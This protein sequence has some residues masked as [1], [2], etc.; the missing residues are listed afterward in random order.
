LADVHPKSS[1]V[2]EYLALSEQHFNAYASAAETFKRAASNAAGIEKLRLLGRAANAHAADGASSLASAVL[3][4][5]RRMGQSAPCGEAMLLRASWDVSEKLKDH[6]ASLAAMERLTEINPED[7]GLQFKLALKHGE[8][9]NNDLSLLHYL[10][11]PAQDRD[12]GTWNNIGVASERVTLP[13][14]SIA[15]YEKSEELGETLATSNLAQALIS[16]GFL[17]DAEQRCRAAMA[18]EGFHENLG[19]TLATV[20]EV[21]R[22]EDKKETDVLARA[23][24]KSEFYG[25]VGRATTLSWP[26]DFTQLWRGPNCILSVK[27]AEGALIATGS[28]NNPRNALIGALS[29]LGSNMPPV[30]MREEYKGDLRG[31]AIEGEVTRSSDDEPMPTLLSS[32]GRGALVLMILSD[33]G[34][35]IDVMES[36]QNNT[37]SYYSLSR[38]PPT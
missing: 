29:G 2:L 10:K 27:I 26:D 32:A 21:L 3:D 25:R 36:R 31:R 17:K 9:G 30:L 4:E 28:Y 13:G 1:G 35:T 6:Q 15:A 37:T 24:R 14:K 33:D 8:E 23:K 5:M 16:A 11:I 34:S 7:T 38:V 19:S 22:A 18:L 12:R 20:N